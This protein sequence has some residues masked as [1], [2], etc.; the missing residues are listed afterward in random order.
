MEHNLQK[1][2]LLKKSKSFITWDNINNQD[3]KMDAEQ[4][5]QAGH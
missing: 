4:N 3:H 5:L 1:I 2:S